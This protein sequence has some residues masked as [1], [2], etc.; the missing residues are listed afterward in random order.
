[1]KSVETLLKE[2][3]IIIHTNRLGKRERSNSL[4]SALRGDVTPMAKGNEVRC[5]STWLPSQGRRVALQGFTGNLGRI[6]IDSKGIF[7]CNFQANWG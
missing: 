4:S 3:I 7:G 6:S 5:G 2:I 1:M